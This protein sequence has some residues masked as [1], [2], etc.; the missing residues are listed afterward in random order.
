MT[1]LAAD[2]R[3]VYRLTSS[4]L[5]ELNEI[6]AAS[7]TVYAGS[8]IE[9]DATAGGPTAYDGTGT[10]FGGF[11]LEG[12]A[13]GDSIRVRKRGQIELSLNDTIAQTHVGD[14]VYAETDDDTFGVTVGSNLPI[15]KIA[16]VLTTGALGTNNCLVEFEAVTHSSV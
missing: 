8:T 13:T 4:T 15:G 2:K 10:Q 16:A 12:G 5:D 1:A 9:I 11:A 7:T 6:L 14:T 3:R